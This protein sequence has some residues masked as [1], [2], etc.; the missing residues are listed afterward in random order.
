MTKLKKILL[1][2]GLLGIADT[3]L[4][5]VIGGG[6]NLGTLLPGIAGIILTGWALLTRKTN[7]DFSF[8]RQW[9]MKTLLFYLFCLGALS[10]T[11]VQALILSQSFNR[12]IPKTDWCIVLGA[13]LRGDQPSLTLRRRL[14]T[15]VNYLE[16]YPDTKVIV[17]G[18]KG[19]GESI[20]EAEAMQRFLLEKDI[21]PTRIYLEDKSTSTLQNLRFSK[22]VLS[23]NDEILQQRI[24]VISSDFHLF[25]VRMIA[26]RLGMN[27]TTIPAPTPWYLLPNGCIREY[28]ALAKSFVLDR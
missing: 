21:S 20:T 23:E 26:K 11:F 12:N 19:V 17:S 7:L 3:T 22:E 15:A 13:G 4:M 18:G 24:S 1:F 27:V 5:F 25:R 28:F 6:I 16:K 8:L 9:N 10:F 2:I 14:T